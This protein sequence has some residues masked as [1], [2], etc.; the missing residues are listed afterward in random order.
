M[1]NH[2]LRNGAPFLAGMIRRF[3]V[4]I[5]LAWLAVMVGLG[6]CVPSLDQVEKEHSVSLS[7][8]DAPT[9]K[10]A[11]RLNE[12]FKESDSGSVAMIVLEGQQPLGD[13]AHKYYDRLILQLKH[14]PEHVQHIQDFWGDP[15]T[16]GA[17]QS[18]DG[19]AAYVQVNLA[20]TPGASLDT[21]SIEA[22]QHI[23]GQTTG[24]PGG[25]AYATG[26]AAIPADMSHSGDRTVLMITAVSLA[27]IF[28]TL[29]LVYRSI[30]TVILL[31]LVVG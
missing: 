11:T 17:A 7:P 8:V 23:V 30:T 9:F 13:E 10:A 22:V 19:K 29:L 24:P 27:V 20:G 4:L 31:L 25:K 21:K 16:A 28:V 2:Q 12:D 15:L 3:S 5:I 14:D 6:V 1:S 26:P 18:A